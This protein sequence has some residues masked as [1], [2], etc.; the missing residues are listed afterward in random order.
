MITTVEPYTLYAIVLVAIYQTLTWY[1]DCT[2]LVHC[3][4]EYWCISCQSCTQPFTLTFIWE[5]EMR[6]DYI[7]VGCGLEAVSPNNQ[8]LH[9]ISFFNSLP[10]L[11]Y[12]DSNCCLLAMN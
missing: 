10:S 7:D 8:N 5:L 6:W 9:S 1:R 4:N 2:L 3:Y 12:G 11:C